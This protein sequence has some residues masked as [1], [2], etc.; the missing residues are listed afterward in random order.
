MRPYQL[1]LL[2]LAVVAAGCGNGGPALAPVRGR[3]TLDGRPLAFKSVRF[4]PEQGTPGAGAGA[5]TDADGNYTLLAV[6]P[7]ATRDVTGVPPGSYRVVVTE[8]AFPIA[9]AQ[10]EGPAGEPAPAT[11]LPDPRPR[12]RPVIPSHYTNAETTELR[13]EVPREGGVRDLALKSRR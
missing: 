7:G 13:V 1:A 6:R 9:A 3:V 12:A 10:P 8:P 4:H 11:G 2:I 5:N